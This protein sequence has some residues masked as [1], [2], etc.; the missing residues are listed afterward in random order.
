MRAE[1]IALIAGMTLVTFLARSPV[2][3]LLGRAQL[4]PPVVRALQF[5]PVALLCAIIAPEL[6]VRDGALA[7]SPGNAY[8]VGGIVSLTVAWSWGNLLIT[9]LAGMGSFLLWRAIAALL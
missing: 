3:A 7:I 1:E 6:L 8:L 4:P 5:V 2:L 9:I